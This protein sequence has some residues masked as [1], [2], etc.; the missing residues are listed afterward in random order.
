MLTETEREVVMTAP[1]RSRVAEAL[2]V[3]WVGQTAASIFWMGSVLSYG[4]SSSGDWLQLFASSA[5]LMANI[6]ALTNAKEN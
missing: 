2:T 5:W 1:A 6:A 3:E 4:I